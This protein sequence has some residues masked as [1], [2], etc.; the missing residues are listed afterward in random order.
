MEVPLPFDLT[1]D[2]LVLDPATPKNQALAHG[3]EFLVN[4]ANIH[5]AHRIMLCTILL[6]T[7][8]PEYTLGECL[9]TAIIWERG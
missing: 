7:K 4:D 1:E 5:E 9:D 3:L 8:H 6:K 2:V